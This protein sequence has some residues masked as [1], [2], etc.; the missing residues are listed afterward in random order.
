MK[1]PILD[2]SSSCAHEPPFQEGLSQ[3]NLEGMEVLERL[4]GPKYPMI[5]AHVH[6]VNFTQNTPGFKNLLSYMDR[7]NI[8]KAAVFGLP[9]MK[10]WSE[11]ER[12]APEYYLDDDTACYYYSFTDGIVAEEYK[13]L[14]SQEQERIYPLICG[15]NPT[16]RY[17]LD[18]IK[19]MYQ[20][21]PGV[22]RGIGE[23]F[24]RHDDLTLLTDGEVSRMNNK[25]L[26]PILEFAVD[27]DLPVLIHNNISTTWIADY[28]KY[29]PE[30]EMM[31]TEFPRAKIV[32]CHCGISRR[33]HA[34]FY[35]KMI[36]RLLAQYPEFLIDYSWI[37]FD[38][39]ICPNGIPD[40]EWIDLTEQFSTRIL[41]GS[42]VIGNFHKM[43]VIN[44]RY[45]AFLDTLSE[46]TRNNICIA[47]AERLF[48]GTK[49]RVET[50]QKKIYPSLYPEV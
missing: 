12:E 27:Y 32:F 6:V 11:T 18:H 24:L 2:E 16:D 37:I 50:K 47:N 28:P 17:A 21:Y 36:R 44:H 41:L 8:Q 5:D 30:L 25:A 42:D 14:S 10:K 40:P 15:F 29:L 39:I 4:S 43:G 33:V 1:E 3:E 19:R 48:G 49:N 22:F 26:Y 23:I 38:E 46:E 9:L 35:K 34:P 31:L 45:T 20:F 7:A 13:K